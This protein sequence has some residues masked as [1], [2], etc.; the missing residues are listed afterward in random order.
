LTSQVQ[1]V[2]LGANHAQSLGAGV[3]VVQARFN[4]FH[5]SP[6]FLVD[7][8]V[9]LGN[10]LVGVLHEAA[11]ETGHPSP[12]AP[13]AFAPAV[14]ALPVGGHVCMFLVDLGQLDVL[15]L[16]SQPLILLMHLLSLQLDF[17]HYTISTPHPKP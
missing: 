9:G 7:A 4:C 15:G 11:A 10:C 12:Q 13:A 17:S 8:V 5:V 2:D 3:Y 14:Q 6:E 1:D 16:P